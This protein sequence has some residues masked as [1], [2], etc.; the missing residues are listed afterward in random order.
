MEMFLK[1]KTAIVIVLL[2]V[3]FFVLN[4]TNFDK[5]IQNFFY[6]ISAPIEKALWQLGKGVSDFWAGVF[7]RKNLQREIEL[8]QENNEELIGKIVALKELKKENEILRTALGVGLEKDFELAYARIIGK[9][10]SEDSILIDKGSKD[11]ISEGFPAVTSQKIIL[12]RIGKVYDDFSEVILISNKNSAFDAK[13]S[14]KEIYGVVKGKGNLGVSLELVQKDKEMLKGDLLVTSALG[15][16]FPKD[17]LVGEIKEIKKSDTELF[18]AA[19]IKPAFD[20][21][22]LDA[23]FVITNF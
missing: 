3:V 6:L 4:F 19:E 14:E 21:Y 2:V 16:V 9:D 20:L 7:E 23:V 18:Q 1:A 11:G 10:V 22:V 17:F 13:I 15:G 12:G 8:L 5:K